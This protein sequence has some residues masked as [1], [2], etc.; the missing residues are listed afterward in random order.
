MNICI[1][2]L[3]ETRNNFKYLIGHLDK[4]LRVLVLVLPK[5]RRH[6][7]TFKNADGD[8][9]NDKNYKLIS[10]YINNGKLLEKYKVI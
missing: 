10:F 3:I 2:D 6:F 7:K 1:S 8:R 5:M 4:I 9:D